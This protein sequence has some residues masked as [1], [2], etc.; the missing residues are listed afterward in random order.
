MTETIKNVLSPLAEEVI[1]I[2]KNG[3]EIPI[4]LAVKLTLGL[5]SENNYIMHNINSEVSK[6]NGRLRDAEKQ[7]KD[8]EKNPS[9]LWLFR[10]KTK[11]TLLTLWGVLTFIVGAAYLFHYY[12]FDVKIFEWMGLSPLLP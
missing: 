8:V 11:E 3:D 1:E 10:N 2:L 12:G 6:I 7:L 5:I 4:S 9:I